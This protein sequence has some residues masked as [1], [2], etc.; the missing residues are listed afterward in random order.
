LSNKYSC[1]SYKAGTYPKLKDFNIVLISFG[2]LLFFRTF[3]AIVTIFDVFGT[4]SLC[5]EPIFAIEIARTKKI[6]LILGE[7]TL[8]SSF[9]TTSLKPTK[10]SKNDQLIATDPRQVWE[11]H[12]IRYPRLRLHQRVQPELQMDD[13]LAF[14]LQMGDR[15]SPY[16]LT[17]FARTI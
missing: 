5:A 17:K 10:K 13:V 11:H 4:L 3:S 7:I 1:P 16:M 12:Y 2:K 9:P 8:A 15:V 6:F 14:R